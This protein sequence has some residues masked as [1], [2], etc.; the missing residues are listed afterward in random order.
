MMFL[1]TGIM[2][3]T[4]EAQEANATRMDKVPPVISVDFYP[5]GARFVFEIFEVAEDPG[6]REFEFYLPGAFDFQNVRPLT[7]GDVTTFS[8]DS[9]NLG[10]WEPQELEPLKRIV[11]DRTREL[12]LLQGRQ[13]ALKQA[14]SLFDAPLSLD[15]KDP[16]LLSHVDDL[17][18]ARLRFE[19][20]MVDARIAVKEA[21][22][23]LRK[24][25]EELKLLQAEREGKRPYNDES[26]LRVCGTAV[27][28]APILVEAYT[29]AAR[30][31]ARYDMDLSSETGDIVAK[32]RAQVWQKTGLNIEGEF[33]FHT[34]H[35]SST[36]PL[37][38]LG[39][40][41]VNLRR[42]PPKPLVKNDRASMA[43]MESGEAN[44]FKALDAKPVSPMEV[45]V[46]NLTPADITVKGIGEIK[47][48]GTREDIAL[49]V[50]QMKSDV[51]LVSIPEQNSETWIVASMDH[52]S[53]SL[54]STIPL[55][56]GPADLTVNGA[57]SGK[58][59]IPAFGLQEQIPFGMASRLTSRKEP[60]V[61]KTGTTWIGKGVLEDGY[62][63]IVTNGTE[64][65]WEVLVKDRI[66]IPVNEK[67]QLEVKK[68]APTPAERDPENRLTWKIDLQPGET[69]RIVVEFTLH[70]PSDE[71][72]EYIR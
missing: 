2:G 14:L 36:V 57:G 1:L 45:P 31:N 23:E 50:F 37:Y 21:K 69:K 8:V 4:G 25:E 52:S 68:I 40:L 19:S 51:L 38:E 33:S 10:R 55:L 48:D 7:Q 44:M 30:W 15:I 59:N 49:G 63:L 29:S 54:S 12:N 17:Y 60:F 9:L 41:R 70:Y 47:G 58:T 34:R 62:T 72:L 71:T 27:K 53:S 67:I 5:S 42:Q 39:P 3:I 18:N 22:E 56:P 66:P 65:A 32:M 43:M 13:R 35:P 46:M 11:A 64:T 20:R 28:P 26:I 61:S 6:Y 16:Q 24:A